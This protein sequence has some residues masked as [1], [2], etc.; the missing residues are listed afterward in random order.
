MDKELV[1]IDIEMFGQQEPFHIPTGEF[2]CLSIAR[3]N[4]ETYQIYNEAQLRDTLDR[5]SN[6]TLVMH[7]ALY[8][9]AQLRRYTEVQ[10]SPSWDTMVVERDL[11]GGYYDSFG[12]DALSR[13]WLGRGLKKEI[14]EEFGEATTMSNEMKEYALEDAVA[15]LE[16][17]IKQRQYANDYGFDLSW[18]WDID[19]PAIWAVLDMPPTRINVGGWLEMA[20]RFG[21]LGQ[22]I[23]DDLGFN[24]YSSKQ[25]KEA[26]RLATGKRLKSTNAKVVLEPLMAELKDPEQKELI[27]T[28]L[29]ARMYRKASNTYGKL[30]PERWAD[31]KGD[32]IPSWRVTGT[33]TGRMACRSPNLMNIPSR[34]LPEFRDMFISKYEGGK[35]I[36]ADVSQQ[37]PRI[38]AWFSKD[39]ALLDAFANDEDIHQFVADRVGCSRELGKDLNLGL[40]YGLTEFG[41]ARN[42]KIPR[43]EARKI[44][45]EYFARFGGVQAYMAT[46]RQEGYRRGYVTT[47]TGRPIHLNPY[48]KQWENNAINAPIQGTAADHTKLAM[49][50][51][52][53]RCKEEN[54]PFPII[55]A[56]HDEL[57]LDVAPGT[58]DGYASMVEWAWLEAGERIVPG[59]PMKVDVAI[60]ESWGVKK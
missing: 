37:E 9:L 14:R 36:V 17:A 10:Q 11:F 22:E 4:G 59:I 19:G 48:A 5:L 57:V 58:E 29:K 27:A 7:N 23:Q 53:L 49:A 28:I 55:M 2:A 15:T 21:D 44:L 16:I 43:E 47:A 33:E 18:Y 30:W 51:T 35:I 52:H 42:A 32:V 26:I 60:G 50:L 45:R 41:L 56:V 1:A 24:V 54:I 34:K 8:D 46:Q 25:V 31:E 12:L 38:L 13:R 39:Q 6:C 20:S 40:S 3:E